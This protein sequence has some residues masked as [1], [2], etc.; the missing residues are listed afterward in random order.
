MQCFWR[1]E[2]HRITSVFPLGPCLV[3][4][5][6]RSLRWLSFAPFLLLPRGGFLALRAPMGSR[7][8]S[9]SRHTLLPLTEHVEPQGALLQPYSHKNLCSTSLGVCPGLDCTVSM[10]MRHALKALHLPVVPTLSSSAPCG[11][12]G[13]LL[14]NARILC[15]VSP[16]MP[17][18]GPCSGTL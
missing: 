18:S 11:S 17:Y 8:S 12:S 4:T 14:E 7:A 6:Q 1:T 10:E 2:C 15:K 9:S 3:L 16:L 13:A 5:G